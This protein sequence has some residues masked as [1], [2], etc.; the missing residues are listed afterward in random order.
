M[1]RDSGSLR[2]GVVNRRRAV[3]MKVG[4]ALATLLQW[5]WVEKA[6][7]GLLLTA[8]CCVRGAGLSRSKSGVVMMSGRGI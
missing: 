1:W 6:E 7:L 5:L 8:L 3:S 4:F 2:L